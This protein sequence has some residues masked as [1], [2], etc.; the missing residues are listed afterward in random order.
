MKKTILGICMVMTIFG[1]LQINQNENEQL[2]AKH[3]D[4]NAGQ[5][6]EYIVNA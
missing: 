1:T 2:N 4:N 6:R 5:T 3:L